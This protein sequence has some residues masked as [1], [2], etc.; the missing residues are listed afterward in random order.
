MFLDLIVSLGMYYNSLYMVVSQE[1]RICFIFKP[2]HPSLIFVS[3][4]AHLSALN[5]IMEKLQL[6]ERKLGRVF[7]SRNG[8]RC[9]IQKYAAIKQNGLNL[10]LINRPR[11]LLASIV[12]AFALPCLTTS[13]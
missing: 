13:S 6:T 1:A 4:G 8:S 11:Q 10:K 7:N 5:L 12:V 2:L 9:A 3:S